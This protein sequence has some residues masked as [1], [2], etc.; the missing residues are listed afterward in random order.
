MSVTLPNAMKKDNLIT[1]LNDH[2]AG[3]VG[4]L[5]L[6]EHMG[7]DAEEEE[8]RRFCKF[9]HQEITSDQTVLRDLIKEL[10]AGEAPVKKAGAWLA[11]KAGWVKFKLAGSEGTE[12]GRLQ[13]LEGL[14]LG[15]T[16]KKELWI[17]LAT[18][19]HLVSPLERLDYPHLVKRAEEQLVQIETE[20]L[21]AAKAAFS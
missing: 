9:L 1:Y 11:E 10:G 13:S 16:G 18:V 12:L 20:R 15:V 19:P 6:L 3:S 14:K 8:F 7:K 4:A 21:K 2:L 17:A 5:E